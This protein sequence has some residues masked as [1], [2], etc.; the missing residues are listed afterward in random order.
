GMSRRGPASQRLSSSLLREL[1]DV[2]RCG[3]LLALDDLVLHL[4]ALGQGAE[5]LALDRGL[6]DEAVLPSVLGGDEADALGVVEPFH[7]SGNTHYSF[8]PSLSDRPSASRCR[9]P[10]IRG[11]RPRGGCPSGA[12][13]GCPPPVRKDDGPGNE[14]RVSRVARPSMR[15][16]GLGPTTL[17]CP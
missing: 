3:P 8:L 17:V 2:R 14:T 4:V 7:G 11:K 15:S 13:R 1:D 16:P 9:R 10:R 12:S 5:S 6:M